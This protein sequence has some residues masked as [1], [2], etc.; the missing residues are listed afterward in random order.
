M[1][2]IEVEL[3]EVAGEHARCM[4]L[5]EDTMR[6]DA[7]ASFQA[8]K[9]NAEKMIFGRQVR[10]ITYADDEGD[11]CTLSALSIA[12]ALEFCEEH[13]KKILK[14]KVEPEK[15]EFSAPP[16]RVKEAVAA[17]EAAA[18]RVAHSRD[19]AA[20]EPKELRD[21]VVAWSDR[22]YT[23]QNVPSEMVGASLYPSK[24]KPAGGGYFSVEATAGATVYIFCEA[25]RD[26]GFPALGW[27]VVEVGRFQWFD[28]KAQKTWGMMVWKKEADGATIE[29]P[30]VDC[31]VGGVAIQ[32]PTTSAPKE[33]VPRTPEAEK[34]I[35]MLKML[36]MGLDIRKVLPKL[37]EVGLRIIDDTQIQ[38]LFVLLDPLVSLAEGSMDL[39][40]LPVHV[41]LGVEVVKSLHKDAQ[42]ELG[43]RAMSAL[44]GVVGDLRN[45]PSTVEVHPNVI[46]DGC[47]QCPITGPC[48][49]CDICGDFDFCGACH[50]K[51]HELHP[52]HDQWT[53]RKASQHADVVSFSFNECSPCVTCDGCNKCPLAP[54]DRHKC[55]VCP[56]Y[57]LCSSCYSQR[58]TIH[59]EHDSFDHFSCEMPQHGDEISVPAA[60]VP[61]GVP[62]P[63]PEAEPATEDVKH[64]YVG[65]EELKPQV[66]S[67]A[68]PIC[69]STPMRRS[70]Q[71][72]DKPYVS[73][74][75]LRRRKQLN[76]MQRRLPQL[77]QMVI[78]RSQARRA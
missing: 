10:K 9:S 17:W 26:G 37:A 76:R 32:M 14:L 72:P 13:G 2:I 38:E 56:D 1:A 57:D 62:P 58:A 68:M 63:V 21:D 11:D 36:T 35:E 74:C 39:D 28:S 4:Y 19:G 42:K 41:A 53:L 71:P 20:I 60:A 29:I 52:E 6:N 59:P 31:L 8:I 77:H 65:D 69:W 30:T 43:M 50:A 3:R 46:C 22:S 44:M 70:A 66:I 15:G 5:E 16:R 78:G 34:L 12:D 24:H 55:K 33:E 61:P 64:F 75:V 54:H 7:E 18:A 67:T 45:V 51:R 23:Y 49:H 40:Q 25:H 47:E 27:S 48:Y 73:Q